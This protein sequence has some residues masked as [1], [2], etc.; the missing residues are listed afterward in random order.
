MYFLTYLG[1]GYCLWS[2]GL[3]SYDS[4]EHHLY[5]S[6]KIALHSSPILCVR[7]GSEMQKGCDGGQND[8]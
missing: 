6:L 3:V 5:T 8:V 1:Q 2:R 7:E 4:S